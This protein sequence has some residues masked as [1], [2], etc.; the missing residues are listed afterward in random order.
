MKQTLALNLI[1]IAALLASAFATQSWLPLAIGAVAE[2]LFLV[3][4]RERTARPAIDRSQE[5][6]RQLSEADRR[7]YLAQC[8]FP[9]PTVQLVHA[10]QEGVALAQAAAASGFEG[11]MG[12][13]IDSRYESGKRFVEGLE[14]ISHLANIGDT[15][16]LVIH[17]AS[18]TH[19]QLSP[20]QQVAA[21]AGPD[22]VRLS[23]GIEDAADIIA[24]IEQ[25]LDQA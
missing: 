17:P 7:R 9:S 2:L 19:R 18:T 1:M 4:G 11:V 13:R 8:L 5:A 24:D 21:G 25:A 12:K 10:S 20:E 14:M 3:V 22:V 16:S 23:I 15:R 6:L